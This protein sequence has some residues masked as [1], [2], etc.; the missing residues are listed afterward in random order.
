MDDNVPHVMLPGSDA[1]WRSWEAADALEAQFPKQE[2]RDFV[3]ACH[4]NGAGPW[5][6]AVIVGLLCV[7]AGENDERPWIWL[8]ALDN[9]AH[10]W[11]VGGCDYTGWDCQ[12][13]LEWTRY[14]DVVDT[15]EA[16]PRRELPA[17]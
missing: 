13:Y 1:Y 9:G 5:N 17:G 12:S 6:D 11:A 14:G 10:W 8:V 2:A 7:E 15:G 16:N 3:Y 4:Y